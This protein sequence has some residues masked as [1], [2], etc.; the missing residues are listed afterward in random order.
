MN[1]GRVTEAESDLLLE[2]VFSYF[3][4]FQFTVNS[5]REEVRTSKILISCV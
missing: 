1:M 2:L 4:A 5:Q 3:T